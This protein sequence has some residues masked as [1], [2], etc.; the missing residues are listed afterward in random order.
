M[1]HASSPMFVHT[2][3]HTHPHTHTHTHTVIAAHANVVP[4]NTSFFGAFTIF[5]IANRK[6]GK[7]FPDLRFFLSIIPKNCGVR[8]PSLRAERSNPNLDCFGKYPRNDDATLRRDH[9]KRLRV[10]PAMTA[11][12]ANRKSQFVIRNTGKIRGLPPHSD[13]TMDKLF[14]QN[15]PK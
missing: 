4:K 11:G 6:F 13:R 15:H 10:K 7:L 8:T 12:C 14:L 1:Q 3:T 5:F 9:D 2:H